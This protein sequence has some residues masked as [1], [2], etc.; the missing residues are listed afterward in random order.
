MEEVSIP[1]SREGHSLRRPPETRLKKCWLCTHFDP[2]QKPCPWT[3]A[4]KLLT[5]SLQVGTPSFSG[6]EPPVF[7]FAWQSNKAILL[8]FTQNSASEIWFN[9]STP[10]PSF[11]HHYFIFPVK[12]PHRSVKESPFRWF[13]TP[14]CQASI[15]PSK[16]PGIYSMTAILTI[17]AA[18]YP[19]SWLI[20]WKYNTQNVLC[21]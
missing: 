5:K 21:H 11:Q 9:T 18:S 12:L 4:V 16:N 15:I 13:E 14:I 10:R 1:H 7:P 3:I 19:N 20:I 2:Y 17:S 8:C 6:H